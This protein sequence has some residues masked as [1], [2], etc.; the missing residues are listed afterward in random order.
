MS[1]IS[2]L[3][4]ELTTV[5]HT[6]GAGQGTAEMAIILSLLVLGRS[7]DISP[8]L[9]TTIVFLWINDRFKHGLPTV[10]I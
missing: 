5:W 4:A 3:V 6:I 2:S 1:D 9:V 7:L 10:D 8:L